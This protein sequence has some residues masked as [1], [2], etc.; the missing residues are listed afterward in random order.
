MVE[1][2]HCFLA[3]TLHH[4]AY[5]FIL[6]VLLPKAVLQ[7]AHEVEV[8]VSFLFHLGLRPFQELVTEVQDNRD[9]FPS[10]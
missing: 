10:L 9:Y 1:I 8:E 4:Q 3:R 5:Y 6:D 7:I 2:V